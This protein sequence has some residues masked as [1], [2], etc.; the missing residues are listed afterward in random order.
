MELHQLRYFCAVVKAGSFTKA[1]DQEGIAQP[2]LSQQIRRLEDSVGAPLF[3]RLGRS[4]RLTHAGSVFYPFAG[5]ILNQ[6]QKATTHVRHLET[7]IRGPLRVGVIPTVLPYLVAPH[8]PEFT[9]QYPEVEVILTEDLT[10]RLIDNLLC[11]EVDLII[12]SLPLR[13][14]DLVCS[15]IMR[16]PLVLVAPK[17][18]KLASLPQVP[19]LDLAGEHLFL[20]KEGHCFR[21]DMLIA[22]KHSHAETAPVFESDHFGSIFPLVASGAGISIAPMMAATHARDCAIIPL[23]KPQARRIGYARLECG[24]NFRPLVAFT[25]WLRLVASQLNRS[26][27]NECVVHETCS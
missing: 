7:D 8:L 16:D 9:R 10:S 21:E 15:E 5:N 14:A 11:G 13:S 1:A 3:V 26:N 22:C 23:A 6:A 20:L 19:H 18:H 4:V 25:K 2:S 12:S 24:A 27:L 17:G